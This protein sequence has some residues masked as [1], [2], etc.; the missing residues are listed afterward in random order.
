MTSRAFRLTIIM[1]LSLVANQCNSPYSM[2]SLFSHLMTQTISTH[3]VKYCWLKKK[4]HKN[5]HIVY[6]PSLS[7]KLPLKLAFPEG[8]LPKSINSINSK[9]KYCP[10]LSFLTTQFKARINQRILDLIQQLTLMKLS[11]NTLSRI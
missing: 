1:T 4:P 5:S 10:L 6:S 7:L 9:R 3:H 8:R 11:E 2:R